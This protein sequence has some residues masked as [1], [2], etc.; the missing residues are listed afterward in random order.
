MENAGKTRILIAFFWLL[1][2]NG[3]GILLRFVPLGLELNYKYFLHAHS[4]LAFLGWVF[5]A[6]FCLITDQFTDKTFSNNRIRDIQ[7]AALQVCNAGMLVSFLLQGYALF[8]IAFSTLHM[9]VSAWFAIS[10]IKH[11]RKKHNNKLPLAEKFIVSGFLFMMLSSFGPLSV[12]YMINQ[13]GTGSTEYTNAI[14]FY[15]H[16]QYN[17]WF[18]FSVLG[19]FFQYL[20]R[21]GI[22]YSDKA[23][24]V[25]LNLMF[26]SCILSYSLSLL[27]CNPPA[28]IWITGNVSAILQ[29]IALAAFAYL[30]WHIRNKLPLLF[31][32]SLFAFSFAALAVKI[33]MQFLSSFPFFMEMAISSRQL[34]VAYLHLVFIG[35]ITISIINFFML[36]GSFRT[37]DK[38]LRVGIL[39]FILAFSVSE[40]FAFVIPVA[41]ESEFLISNYY[42]VQAGCSIVMFA[43][44]VIALSGRSIRMNIH[45]INRWHEQLAVKTIKPNKHEHD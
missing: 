12:P 23:G 29:L 44:L 11:L 4:H 34:I 9:A 17:G 43:A 24:R 1:L 15:L 38:N 2:V 27:W 37:D 5:T 36:N 39:L 25:A 18:V 42:T 33:V 14:Y 3:L 45:F 35:V 6:L 28:I 16:F 26:V 40:A 32:R 41:G 19:L 30:V 10:T 20:K 13:Y 22:V 31:N 8:S 21:S 7:F